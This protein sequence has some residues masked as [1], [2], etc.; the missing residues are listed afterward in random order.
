MRA[1]KADEIRRSFVE[2]FVKKGHVH[3]PSSGLVPK[4]DPTLLFTN[5]GM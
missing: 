1:M 5:A 4:G 2:Y 3:V